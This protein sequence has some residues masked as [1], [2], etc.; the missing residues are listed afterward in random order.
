MLIDEERLLELRCCGAACADEERE[1]GER[2][3]EALRL[4]LSLRTGLRVR[5]AGAGRKARGCEK[6]AR[7]PPTAPAPAGSASC[8]SRVLESLDTG[9]K[10]T[11]AGIT[12]SFT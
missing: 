6:L 7:F 5:A 2:E 8:D 4:L 3:R 11:A 12:S 9:E 1:R 10:G